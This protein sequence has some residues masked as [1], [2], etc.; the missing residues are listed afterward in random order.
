ME[1]FSK[2][3][4]IGIDPTAGEKPFAYAALDQDLRLLALGTGS[5]DEVLAFTAGQRQAVVA[6]CSPRQPNLGVMAKR[7]VRQNLS[8]MPSSGR[9][10]NFRLADFLLRQ[11]HITIPQ[12]PSN[13]EACPQWM[14]NG[15]QLYQ[16]LAELGYA[17]YPS[18]QAERQML[19]VYPHAAFSVLLGVLPFQKNTLEGRIQRQL[20]LHEQR[21]QVPDPMRVFEE[22]T[23]HRLLKGMLALDDLLLPGELDALVG[24]YTA[25]KAAIHPDQVILLGDE[26]EG[27]IILPAA[28]KEIY[29]AG[30]NP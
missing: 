28:L 9:W 21:L 11:H 6:I 23:R 18:E 5:V 1:L 25:W 3:T 12:T 7:E 26:E 8:P 10:L 19:E 13:V 24:A 15:F 20:I 16:R 27:Q 4:L 22:I 29:Y 2:A 17:L 14:R 30:V